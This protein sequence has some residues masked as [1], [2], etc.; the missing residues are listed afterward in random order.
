MAANEKTHRIERVAP[1]TAAKRKSL[2]D[3]QQKLSFKRLRTDARPKPQQRSN[4]TKP[5]DTTPNA[6]P[7]KDASGK[8]QIEEEI[9][10]IFSAPPNTLIIHACNCE[11]SWGAGIAKAF[12]DRYP[13]A[14]GPYVDYC[15]EHEDNAIGTALLIPPS[16]DADEESKHFVGCLFTSRSK[17]RKKDSPA[18]ILNATS[19]AMEDMLKQVKDWNAKAAEGEGEKVGEVRMC[20]INSGLFNVPWAKTRLVLEGID[21]GD[22]D[23]K[24]IKVVS[25]D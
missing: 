5:K 3:G 8:L 16:K 17:G 11:G 24:V 18:K 22:L 4:M 14:Y 2:E 10:D 6:E 13:A 1:N 19:P 12:K 7:A 9:G 15:D 20:K 21:V 25:L 23:V